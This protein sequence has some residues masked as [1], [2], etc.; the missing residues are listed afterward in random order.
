MLEYYMFQ[1]I[2]NVLIFFA[3]VNPAAATGYYYYYYYH[4]HHHIIITTI[5][6]TDT[7]EGSGR[8]ERERHTYTNGVCF[9]LGVTEYRN[10][11]VYKLN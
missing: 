3:S 2:T 1:L 8:R 11:L 7:N 9:M 6:V 10:F 4:H 5:K